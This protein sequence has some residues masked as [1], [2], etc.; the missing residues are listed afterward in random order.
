[1][2]RPEGLLLFVHVTCLNIYVLYT[3]GGINFVHVG[4]FVV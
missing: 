1:M 4:L 3:V 2:L